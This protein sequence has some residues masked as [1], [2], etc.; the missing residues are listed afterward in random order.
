MSL[1]SARRDEHVRLDRWREG[2]P[3]STVKFDLEQAIECINDDKC[4]QVMLQH[5]HVHN[6]DSGGQHASEAAGVSRG[7]RH[8][9]TPRSCSPVRWHARLRRLLTGVARAFYAE[10][11][12]RP[13]DSHYQATSAISTCAI[14]LAIALMHL[15]WTK[16]A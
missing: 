5:L 8:G 7:E 13:E 4:M 11:L 3:S 14:L 16:L 2:L 15:R 1:G 9:V 10:Q 6:E 12:Y